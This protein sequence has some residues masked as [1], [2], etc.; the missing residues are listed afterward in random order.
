MRL[1]QS[2]NKMITK[3]ERRNWRWKDRSLYNVNIIFNKKKR[4]S[5]KNKYLFINCFLLLLYLIK[6]WFFFENVLM[7]FSFRV[8]CAWRNWSGIYNSGSEDASHCD[9][10]R[11]FSN[12]PRACKCP[13][14]TGPLRGRWCWRWPGRRWRSAWRI[15]PAASPRS[16]SCAALPW[17]PSADATSGIDTP[18]H[19][20]FNS[21]QL[22]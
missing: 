16:R 8:G 9:R 1:Y 17:N 15:W 12:W 6:M 5:R 14:R 21:S 7:S 3:K 10:W 22:H 19:D 13:C 20:L 11:F 4:K 18:V 2:P